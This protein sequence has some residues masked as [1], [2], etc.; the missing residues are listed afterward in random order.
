LPAIQETR[1][2]Y[3]VAAFYMLQWTK[4][5]ASQYIEVINVSVIYIQQED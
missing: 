2:A 5:Y 3:Y 4:Q 1:D